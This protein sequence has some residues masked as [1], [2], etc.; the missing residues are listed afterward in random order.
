M[1]SKMLIACVSVIAAALLMACSTNSDH[2][3]VAPVVRPLNQ[4]VTITVELNTGRVTQAGREW[5]DPLGLVHKQDRVMEGMKVIGDL[6]GT[7]KTTLTS[8]TFNPQTGEGKEDLLVEFEVNW[9]GQNLQG[10]FAGNMTQE[11]KAESRAPAS[12]NA[13]GEGGCKGLICELTLQPNEKDATLLLG[14]GRIFTH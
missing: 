10:V 11:Y 4:P 12:L 2:E 14:Q 9:P 1:K 5:T 6:V 3:I 7:M 13:L 8:S